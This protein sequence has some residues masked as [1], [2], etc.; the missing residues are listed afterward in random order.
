MYK[1][2][3]ILPI[4]TTIVLFLISCNS[5]DLMIK[6]N[7]NDECNETLSKE[8]VFKLLF[9]IGIDEDLCSEIHTLIEQEV[10]SGNDEN[11]VFRDIL[12][13]KQTTRSNNTSILKNRLLALLEHTRATEA[14]C[15]SN[16]IA[17]LEHSNIFIYWPYSED[18][19]G[20]ELPTLVIAPEDEDV[21][22]CQGWT[23]VNESNE[24]KAY[25]RIINEDYAMKHPVWVINQAK[26]DSN[27]WE[28]RVVPIQ[29]RTTS[30]TV[31]NTSNPWQVTR[32]RVTHQYDSWIAGGSEIDIQVAYPILDGYV[33][34][35]NRYRLNFTRKDIKNKKWKS[36]TDI[37]L[38]TNWRPEQI[39]N[40]LV[41]SES[42]GGS[43]VE[44]P[45]SVKYNNKD[46][47]VEF[48][49]SVKITIESHDERIAQSS[50]DRDFM[51]TKDTLSFDNGRVSMIMPIQNK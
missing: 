51:L 49:A 15:S 1:N 26:E 17:Q 46:N 10:K 8:T 13:E 40:Y 23:L 44:I 12:A 4:L 38:N 2:K 29:T 14:S 28:Y 24:I 19:D 25:P 42:D 45:A 7:Y 34:G 30:S 16:I 39:T 48:N 37:Y 21:A 11:I 41:I 43:K 20:K 27:N 47:G 6:S 5:D 33:A 22:V 50:I 36:L 3:R 9:Q 32:M 35:T 31:Q 18:W